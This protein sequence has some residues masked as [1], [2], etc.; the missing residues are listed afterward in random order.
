MPVAVAG[1]CAPDR[2]STGD[3]ALAAV[4]A[5]AV[6]TFVVRLAF[7]IDS[8]QFLDL[9]VWLWPQTATLF[10]LGAVGAERGWLSPVPASLLRLCR[11]GV[12][13]AA[14]LMVVLVLLSDG[15]A[16]FEGGWHWEAAG[17]AVVEGTVA[18]GVSLL[19][20]DWSRRHVVPHGRW[21]RRVA[22]AAY[23]AFVAQGPVLVAL[24][25]ALREIPVSG[26]AKLVVVAVLGVVGSFALGALPGLWRR[27]QPRGRAGAAR[28][29]L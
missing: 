22:A 8:A 14:A 16:A 17:M 12:A 5:I 9:H 28:A 25:L 19:V 3:G 10:V 24:A 7:P 23:G 11:L 4:A 15:P 13:G 21:E 6:L 2:P 1:A 18:V 29:S 27:L 26:D 20:L